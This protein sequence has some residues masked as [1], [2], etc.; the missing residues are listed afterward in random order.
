MSPIFIIGFCVRVLPLRRVP[1]DSGGLGTLVA[2]GFGAGRWTG[3]FIVGRSTFC[4]FDPCR[5]GGAVGSSS[6]LGVSVV[7]SLDSGGG[8]EDLSFFSCDAD[9]R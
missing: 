2:G 5:V 1:D 4:T 7:G 8:L 9:A 3:Q 6:G